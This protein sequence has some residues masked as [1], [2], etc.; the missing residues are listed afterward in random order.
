[1]KGGRK[2]GRKV[3]SERLESERDGGELF[4]RRVRPVREVAA[5]RRAWRSATFISA[6]P[7]RKRA[8][9]GIEF[10]VVSRPRLLDMDKIRLR[11]AKERFTSFPPNPEAVGATL[12]KPN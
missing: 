8:Q 12:E 5:M 10:L 1:M 7:G 6:S 9:Q 3:S 4:V 11:V 2:E